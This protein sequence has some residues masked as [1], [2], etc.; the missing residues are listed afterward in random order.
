MEI[1]RA[2]AYFKLPEPFY[3]KLTAVPFKNPRILYWNTNLA[4]SFLIS[5]KNVSIEEL[6]LIFAGKNIPAGTTPIAQAYA[7]HQFGHFTPQLGDGRARL[8]G[9]IVDATGTPHEVHLKGS[10][11]TKFSRR[12][13][14]FATLGSVVRELIMSEFMHSVGIP[15]TRSLAVI[16]TDETVMRERELPGA[17]LVRTAKSHIRVGT[18]EYF[19]ARGDQASVQQLADFVIDH[20]YYELKN[21]ENPYISL[22]AQIIKRQAHL[23]AQWLSVGFIHGVM[24][25]DNTSITCETIDFGP[26]AMM[27]A[28][29]PLKVFSSIDHQGRYAYARQP[30]IMHWNLTVLGYCLLPLFHGDKK[31]AEA[32]LEKQLSEFENIFHGHWLKLMG[33][34][35][36]FKNPQ[37]QDVPMIQEFL[38]LL[39]K[40]KID[41]TQG[42]GRLIQPDVFFQQDDFK[43]WLKKWRLRQDPSLDLHLINPALIP[44]NH[45]VE[46]VIRAAEDANDFAP[47]LR[48][49]EAIRKP[50]ADIE[51]F[52]DLQTPALPQE[53]ITQ[54]FCGT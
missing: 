12:G 53:E 18:F 40:Y 36:G 39:Q 19:A 38:G 49:L 21:L 46:K 44:R 42:F 10:G 4:E 8:I 54:T 22:F 3:E 24:N 13:D 5:E 25:T 1:L 52:R 45:Q 14:G 33:H 47:M 28:Y 15:T 27:E 37:E 29:D 32:I 17:I 35:L 41:F 9:E 2:S 31:V 43:D 7:G 23:M 48:L 6:A 11:P 51:Q 26:C 34:K 16:A 50:F 20:H 30:Q